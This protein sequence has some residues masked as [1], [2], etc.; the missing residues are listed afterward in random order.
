MNQLN[1]IGQ[2]SNQFQVT[3][4]RKQSLKIVEDHVE[5]IQN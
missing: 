5:A 3:K 4:A 2:I 1:E